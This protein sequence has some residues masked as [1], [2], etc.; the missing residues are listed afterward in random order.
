MPRIRSVKPDFY[1]HER[2]QE[3]GPLSMLIFSGLWTQCDKAGRFP[4][5][6]RTLKLDI[7]PFI[8]FDMEAELAKLA[9][10]LF[11]IKYESDGDFFGV[12]PTFLDHQRISGK[13][14][15]EPAKYP[16]PPP[17]KPK[18]TRKLPQPEKGSSGEAPGKQLPGQEME[19]VLGNGIGNGD[20]KGNDFSAAS[21][22]GRSKKEIRD[23]LWEGIRQVTGFNPKTPG[24]NARMGRVVSDLVTKGAFPEDVPIRAGRYR[25]AWPK[26]SLTPEALLKHWDAFSADTATGLNGAQTNLD[27]LKRNMD[28]A[29]AQLE[30]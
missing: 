24:D 4:W 7:L 18:K 22:P 3:L 17:A 11:V 12:I 9:D 30:D 23:G 26:V 25:Q 5:K 19:L 2:L 8:N 15:Q 1:R 16:D 21:A 10:A 28:A 13:E 27:T 14:A 29:L 20:G 6:P